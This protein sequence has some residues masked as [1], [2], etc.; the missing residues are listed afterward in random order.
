MWNIVIHDGHIIGGASIMMMRVR[1]VAIRAMT[2]SSRDSHHHLG[3]DGVCG[4]LAQL[5][6]IAQLRQRERVVDGRVR[7]Q[8]R[9]QALRKSDKDVSINIITIII[10]IIIII[11]IMIITIMIITIIIIIIT[12]I[13]CIL[14]LLLLLLLNLIILTWILIFSTSMSLTR[15]AAPGPG[16]RFQASGLRI[17]SAQRFQSPP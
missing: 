16:M 10:I 1:T 14:L 4:A 9:A 3:D 15:S 8:V 6:H 17:S 5:E 2:V 13:I 11:I 7:E 12:T